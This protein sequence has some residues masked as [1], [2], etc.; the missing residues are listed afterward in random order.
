MNAKTG[1]DLCGRAIRSGRAALAAGA[2]LLPC[3]CRFSAATNND[4]ALAF[5]PRI[6]SVAEQAIGET[7]AKFQA[8]GG[9][10]VVQEVRTGNILAMA[11]HTNGIRNAANTEYEP[12]TTLKPIILAAAL[13]ENLVTP[14]TEFDCGDGTWVCEGH[15][16][17]DIV[18]GTVSVRSAMA[19]SSNIAFS[20][21]GIMLGPER[22]VSYLRGFGFGCK[23]G[24]GLPDEA[25]GALYAA[26]DWT[27]LQTSRA[28]LGQGV[29]V[30]ALQMANAY[31]C[32]ANGGALMLPYFK[33]DG[34][35]EVTDRPVTPEAARAVRGMLR[36]AEVDGDTGFPASMGGYSVAG[37]AG[38]AQRAIEGG[39][40][41]TDFYA[42][43][44]GFVPADNPV[45][46]VIVVIDAPKPQHTGGAVAAPAF[47]KIA[48]AT[49][50]ILCLKAASNGTG[51]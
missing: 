20:R 43:F 6:Q 12:G 28:G 27:A 36:C 25:D 31:S 2:L 18:Q 51:P 33:R 3:G 40:S 14:D 47:A 4:A 26:K 44:A 30:T 39:Y 22:L 11:S 7:V 48:A 9:W 17:R 21:M 5:N 35:P 49:A 38:T 41:E 29:A 13:N 15:T 19:R 23:P 45:F 32:I 24:C 50:R 42:S 10:A 46:C 8:A 34:K 1:G 16:I 37:K